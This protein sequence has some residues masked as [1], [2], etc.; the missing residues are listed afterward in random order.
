M[1]KLELKIGDCIELL[2]LCKDKEFDAIIT[3]PQYGI[4]SKKYDATTDTKEDLE[5][6]VGV[7]LSEAKRV[8]NVVAVMTG[9]K[10]T[11]LYNGC[12]WRLSWVCPAG[13]GRG[14]WG[15]TCW[16]PIAVYGK[17]PYL[18]KG[19]M[20]DTFVDYKAKRIGYDHPY[21]KPLSIM[22]WLVNRCTLPGWSIL[23]PFMGSG[24]TGEA[25]LSYGR[26]FTGFEISEKYFEVAKE[27][28][29]KVSQKTFLFSED[30][31]IKSQSELFA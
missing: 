6:I 26:R 15:F 3:D 2:S 23:D 31:L 13:T 30:E 17:D 18:G 29:E 28:L 12:D 25:A 9:V 20:P 11:E 24:S 27:R 4:N 8:A 16:T 22:N 14:P 10:N 21:E 7:F 1:N 5:K 19:S